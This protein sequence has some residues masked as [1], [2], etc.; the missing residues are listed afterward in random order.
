LYPWAVEDNDEIE[1]MQ[2]KLAHRE[3]KAEF[4]YALANKKHR[5][6]ENLRNEKQQTEENLDGKA[7]LL[8]MYYIDL[9][10][11]AAD[12]MI[13]NDKLNIMINT[14]LTDLE[15]ANEK[16][17]EIEE[18]N[19]E[20]L[21]QLYDLKK[22]NYDLLELIDAREKVN[23]VNIQILE[24]LLDE[25]R[26][27]YNNQKGKTNTPLSEQSFETETPAEPTPNLKS[28]SLAM[29]DGLQEKL[30]MLEEEIQILVEYGKR[31]DKEIEYWTEEYAI[32]CKQIAQL[33]NEV[34]D[35]SA[36]REDLLQLVNELQQEIYE[37]REEM[38]NPEAPEIPL[39]AQNAQN[40]ENIAQLINQA[41][42]TEANK[43]NIPDIDKKIQ[44]L[45]KELEQ[46][47]LAIKELAIVKPDNTLKIK[48][49]DNDLASP[50]E[51][52]ILQ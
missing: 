51:F 49:S 2:S 14:L 31:K 25:N 21:E 44:M 43:E 3:R 22:E 30:E 28:K 34:K 29:I 41:N 48:K 39:E 4:L 32:N 42:E 12:L 7:D 10:K 27:L 1:E 6:L 47:T 24:N 17:F 13:D 36:E 8:N 50:L 19:I 52:E 15:N 40:E 26:Y 23:D 9:E 18:E 16:Q 37:I 11:K 38:P 33:E 5:E 20:L 46:E 45:E 35:L